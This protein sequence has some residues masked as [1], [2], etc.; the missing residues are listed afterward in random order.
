MNDGAIQEGSAGELTIPE[1]VLAV[2]R[3]LIPIN[4][5]AVATTRLRVTFVSLEPTC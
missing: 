1:R 2:Y 4:S 5:V 3:N